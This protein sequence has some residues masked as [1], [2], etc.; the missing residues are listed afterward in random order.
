MVGPALSQMA[1]DLH[2]TNTIEIEISL[3][4][5]I[6][7]VSKVEVHRAVKHPTDHCLYAFS[8]P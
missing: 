3:S 8:G 5:F 2:M 4:I 1:T 7:A 6:L